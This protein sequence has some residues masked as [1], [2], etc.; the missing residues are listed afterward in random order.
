MFKEIYHK[1]FWQQY[2]GEVKAEDLPYDYVVYDT[3]IYCANEE[4]HYAKSCLLVKRYRDGISVFGR[5]IMRS[6]IKD[7]KG[8][9][10]PSWEHDRSG[11]PDYRGASFGMHPKQSGTTPCKH[12]I[13]NTLKK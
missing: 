13:D 3:R 4:C 7:A 10:R 12:F 1:Y 6:C 5:K 8:W 11:I 2:H 9:K